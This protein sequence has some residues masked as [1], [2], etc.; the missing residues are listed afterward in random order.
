MANISKDCIEEAFENLKSFGKDELEDYVRDVFARAR[1]FGED[2]AKNFDKAAEEINKEKFASIM[3][4]ATIKANNVLKFNKNASLIKEGKT[5]QWGLIGMRGKYYGRSIAA[6]Q[7]AEF[8]TFLQHTLGELNP[9]EMNYAQDSKNAED[10][11]DAYDGKKIANPMAKKIADTFRDYFIF[12]NARLVLT[13]AMKFDEMS[14]DRLFGAVHDQTRILNGN[15]SLIRVALDKVKKKYDVSKNNKL[16]RDE[17]KKHLDIMGTFE[18]TDAVD[19]KGN[20]D[21]AKVDKILDRIYNNITTGRSEIFTKSQVANDRDALAKKSRMFFKWKSMR[22][23]YEYNKI[24]GK[25]DLFH[26]FISDARSASGKAGTASIWGDNIYSMYNDLRHAQD[27][28]NTKS[29]AWWW[30][31]DQI[32]KAVTHQDQGSIRPNLSQFFAN[33][34]SLSTMASL[35]LI[36][37]DSVSDIGYIASFAQRMGIDYTRAWTNQMTHIFDTMS[38]E[39]RQR[40]AR[41]MKTQVDSHLGYMGRWGDANSASE[42][43]NKVNTAYFK[44]NQLESFDRGN[45]VGMMNLVAQHLFENSDKSFDE[46][47]LSL[48][49]WVGKFLDKDEWDLLRKN[50]QGKLFTTD[51]VDSLSEDQIKSYYEKTDQSLPLSQVRDDLYRKVHTM[52]TITAE[53]AVLSPSEFEKAFMNF[54]QKGSLNGEIFGLFS[55]FKMYTMA[56]IDRVLVQGYKDA[57]QNQQ[58]L[59]WATSMLAGTV[60][61]SVMSIYLHNVLMNKTMPDINQMNTS[62]RMKYALTILAPSLSLFQSMLDPRNQN[63]SMIMSLLGSPSTRL[64]SD[65]MATAGS[66]LTGDTDKARKNLGNAANYFLPLQNTPII[67]PLL[68]YAMGDKAYMQPGQTALFGQ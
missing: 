68:Q 14:E 10:I 12:R 42:L 6:A 15:R 46:L 38:N 19:L 49:N 48:R 29:R 27:I 3:E 51:N 44:A 66:L 32:F 2:N 13:N 53:N 11:A 18:K 31:T 57:D 64:I 65:A 60:P 26:M 63:S 37:L 20:I 67:T 17:I 23:Q 21:M 4:D 25:G 47:P 50:N 22:S 61:L 33:I 5:D 43:L 9:D 1:S 62:D 7:K 54:G 40:I 8:E 36:S 45:K 34:K 24:Y 41:L 59:L 30:Q 52:F 55:H 58:K 39:D 16:W 28:S 56:Y 35:P